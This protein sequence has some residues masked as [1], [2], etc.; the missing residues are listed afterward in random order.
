VQQ[1]GRPP[2]A[3]PARLPLR[4]TMTALSIHPHSGLDAKKRRVVNALLAFDSI[5]DPNRR[6]SIIKGLS[7]YGQIVNDPT[8]YQHVVNIVDACARNTLGFKELLEQFEGESAFDEYEEL[9]EALGLLAKP[10]APKGLP[11]L[12]DRDDQ[13]ERLGPVLR[14]T[15]PKAGTA[16]ANRPIV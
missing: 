5:K 16:P 15:F 14:S 7:F 13:H 2:P 10:G 4:G 8:T 12:C 11:K 6:F 3:A 1:P 9:M